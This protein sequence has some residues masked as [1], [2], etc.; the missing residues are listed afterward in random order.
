MMEEYRV[1]EPEVRGED[2]MPT[3]TFDVPEETIANL[4]GT[5]DQFS[6]EMRRAAAIFWYSKG[7]ITQGQGAELTGLSRREFIEALGRAE[8]EVIQIHPDELKEEVERD[9]QARRERLAA[10]LPDARRAP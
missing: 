8:V 4:G 9:L 2:A 7:M 6:R 1:A 5:P 3:V 10:D